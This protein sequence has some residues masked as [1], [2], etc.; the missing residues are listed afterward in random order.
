MKKKIIYGIFLFLFAFG[1]E[2]TVLSMNLN[3]VSYVAYLVTLVG[4]SLFLIY[5]IP[6][7]FGVR[8]L[9]RR[10]DAS[11]KIFVVAFICGIFMATIFS[12]YAN[13]LLERFWSHYMS[14]KTLDKWSAALTG[15]F[16]EEIIKAVVALFALTLFKL[17]TGKDYLLAGLG[18]GIGFQFMEDISYMLP[19]E[20]SKEA[21]SDIF[22]QIL[23]RFSGSLASHWTYTAVILVGIY[24]LVKSGKKAKGV[25]FVLA[26]V[27]LH[28]AW[29]TPLSDNQGQYSLPGPILTTLTLGL[30]IMALCETF[31][32]EKLIKKSADFSLPEEPSISEASISNLDEQNSYSAVEIDV[33]EVNRTI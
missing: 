11:M 23:D 3:Q 30:F 32:V 33:V 26:P 1:F 20:S 29:N 22:P 28:F 5:L 24:L 15:P 12:S 6:F 19:K 27:V 7:I 2:K 18:S 14:A 16:T 9:A 13:E 21:L 10:L 31:R 25:F 4:I 17:N 8:Y